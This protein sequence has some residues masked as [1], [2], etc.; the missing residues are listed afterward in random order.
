[1]S[2][3]FDDETPP[4]DLDVTSSK[5]STI[6]FRGDWKPD[7]IYNVGDY[8]Y[9]KKLGYFY[10]ATKKGKSQSK[11]TASSRKY[12]PAWKLDGLVYDGT[13]QWEIVEVTSSQ[14]S[15]ARKWAPETLYN[16]KEIILPSTGA[17]TFSGATT[18]HYGFILKRIILNPDWPSVPE[19][20]IQD[21]TVV[22]ETRLSYSKLLPP[23]RLKEKLYIELCEVMDNLQLH[24]E[25][26]FKDVLHKF[27][28]RQEL[29]QSSLEQIVGEFGYV[30]IAKA[31]RLTT[32]ELRSLV[33]YMGAIHAL[34]GSHHGL[35]LVFELM[36]LTW[37]YEEWYEWNPKGEPDTWALY[38]QLDITKVPADLTSRIIQFTRQYVYPILTKFEVT[39]IVDLIKAGI[40]VGGFIDFEYLIP[41]N[42]GVYVLASVAGFFDIDYMFEI[43]VEWIEVLGYSNLGYVFGFGPETGNI[44][45]WRVGHWATLEME[46][47]RPAITTSLGYVITP[48]KP[49]L[50]AYDPDYWLNWNIVRSDPI[51][52]IRIKRKKES[53]FL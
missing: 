25:H 35:D 20:T 53:D 8:V 18:T 15:T 3:L 19:E 52:L 13:I 40:V 4:R 6:T 7:T 32:E 14:I 1:M 21:G 30:Y 5:I 29:R 31:L 39:Y 51:N 44:R 33:A 9:T 34:K 50:D 23:E 48:N 49:S 11:T 22:W 16:I 12:E 24:E 47:R 38:L 28:D 46:K 17:L 41:V 45:T 2:Q 36:K 37:Q 26:Y 43:I 42:T 10:L 27:N